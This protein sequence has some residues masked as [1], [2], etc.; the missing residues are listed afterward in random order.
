MPFLVFLVA[1]LAFRTP[2]Q[3]DV[4]LVSLVALGA[5][6]EPH[7]V[8]ETTSWTRSSSRSTS[9]TPTTASTF[10]AGAVPSSTPSPTDSR[11]T[12]ARSRVRSRWPHGAGVPASARRR[13][14]ASCAWSAASSV[15]SAP[16]GS[17]S[18]S[19]PSSRCSPREACVATS[20]SWWSRSSLAIAVLAGSHTGPLD[21]RHAAH[22]RLGDRVGPQEPRRAAINMVEARPLFGF[23]WSRFTSHSTGLLRAGLRLPADGDQAGRAQHAALP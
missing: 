18:C 22:Q 17:A 8:F 15:S 6:L 7:S 10:S 19:G 23:G 21:H 14:S 4:L 16:S 1:P 20:W 3:R 11:S 2:H 5:Y 9:S 12:R 13:R